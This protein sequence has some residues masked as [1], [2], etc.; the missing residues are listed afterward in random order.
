MSNFYKDLKID[1]NATQDQIRVA[2]KKL[3]LQHHPDKNAMGT[4]EFIRIKTAYGVLSDPIKRQI[5]DSSASTSLVSI[6]SEWINN[7]LA[8]MIIL[9]SRPKT[10]TI[11]LDVSF[12]QVYSRQGK[13]VNVKVK[14][15]ID[16]RLQDTTESLVFFWQK[17][18]ITFKN[19]GDDCPLPCLLH[20]RGDIV[21]CT[22]LVSNANVRI[23]TLFSQVD[24]FVEAKV[25]LRDFYMLPVLAIELCEGVTIDVPNDRLLSYC[26][27]NVGLPTGPN[28]RSDVYIT[29]ALDIPLKLR[30]EGR[31]K[32]CKVLSKYFA[33]NNKH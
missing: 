9:A 23:D 4:E 17:D 33:D 31:S 7:V 28:S 13:R 25:S 27:R 2:Y 6:S 5:Y 14:R 30:V 15:W 26:M 1:K 22:N 21:I 16:G 10:I 24:V 12:R 3:A 19:R 18:P 32:L 11:H 20:P 29:L 8:N